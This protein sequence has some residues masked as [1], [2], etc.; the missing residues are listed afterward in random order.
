[1]T[2]LPLL[3]DDTNF[4][5]STTMHIIQNF[6]RDAPHL[7]PRTRPLQGPSIRGYWPT[8]GIQL[9]SDSLIP[10]TMRAPQIPTCNIHVCLRQ[11]LKTPISL[12]QCENLVD[13]TIAHKWVRGPQ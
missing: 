10:L 12:T 6:N 7:G 5:H 4:S 3:Y 8:H 9:A 13:C 2:N 11:W 1:M